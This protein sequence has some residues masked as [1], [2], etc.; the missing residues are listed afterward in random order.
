[1]ASLR[2]KTNLVGGLAMFMLEEGKIFTQNEYRA[3]RGYAPVS[4]VQIK[5]NFG[6]WA[7]CLLF[8][9]NTQPDLWAELENLGKPE[10]KAPIVDLSAIED[11]NGEYLEG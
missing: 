6:N 9:K 11:S 7:R 5:R 3:L 10:V 8:L 1:M 2:Q 4:F